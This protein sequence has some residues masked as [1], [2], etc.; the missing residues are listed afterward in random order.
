MRIS[1]DSRTDHPVPKRGCGLGLRR[2]CVGLLLAIQAGH[3]GNAVAQRPVRL[4][5]VSRGVG[6]ACAVLGTDP[7]KRTGAGLFC[8]GD[9]RP[10]AWEPRDRTVWGPGGRPSASPR[11]IALPARLAPD[12]IISLSLGA[13]PFAC[14]VVHDGTVWCWGMNDFGELGDGGTDAHRS[15]VRVPLPEQAVAVSAG[16]YRACAFTRSAQIYCWGSNEDGMLGVGDTVSH[17]RPVRVVAGAP[18]A[19]V[20]VG[21]SG[22]S[23]GLTISG[24]ILCWGQWGGEHGCRSGDEPVL[25]PSAP[26]G[27]P[28]DR[29]RAVSVGTGSV[30]ALSSD[31]AVH[32]WGDNSAGQL[33]TAPSRGTEHHIV[34]LPG[35]ERAIA[36]SAA[37][38]LACALTVSRH[39]ACWGGNNVG[40]LGR[41]ERDSM[42]AVPGWILSDAK[43]DSLSVG[44]ATACAIT[45]T[46]DLECWGAPHFGVAAYEAEMRRRSRPVRVVFP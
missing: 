8:W 3:P 21:A 45:T 42:V 33:G 9:E 29:Y 26:V 20:S 16:D 11:R 25:I 7:V 46:Q 36:V 44:G 13:T 17:H 28:S 12:S 31:S 34:P 27:V 5:S 32:C 10:D 37:I 41:M 2:L 18:F 6:I 35:D 40:Q 1:G 30:C 22:A 23:C 39:V 15:P 4:V 38:H 14:V 19:A 24:G 43:Y